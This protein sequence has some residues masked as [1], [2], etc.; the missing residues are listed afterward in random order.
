MDSITGA[1]SMMTPYSM[2]NQLA[3]NLIKRKDTNG[4]KSLTADEFGGS[5]EVFN[6]IDKNSDGK[7]DLTELSKSGIAKNLDQ[8]TSSLISSLDKNGD[9]VL[10]ADELKVS[11][12][13]FSKIDTNGDGTADRSELNNC[14]IANH[15]ASQY[16]QTMN[17]T[18][19]TA[20]LISSSNIIA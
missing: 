16:Q 9:N 14:F 12:E 11:A 10:S 20:S 19:S 2:N 6:R 5:L 13:T 15:A 1:S 4:D 18:N 17:S 3:Q 8:Q 7:I